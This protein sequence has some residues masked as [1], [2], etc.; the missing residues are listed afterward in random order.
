MF[1]VGNITTFVTEF[2]HLWYNYIKY[3]TVILLC[4]LKMWQIF[5]MFLGEMEVSLFWHFFC[6]FCLFKKY[7]IWRNVG[8][9]DFYLCRSG[10]KHVTVLFAFTKIISKFSP[11]NVFFSLLRIM[12]CQILCF[13]I[14]EKKTDSLLFPSPS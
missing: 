14:K 3:F 8:I 5:I 13:I 6:N 9:L 10:I 11:G 7:N 1:S 4:V 12:T 2:Q